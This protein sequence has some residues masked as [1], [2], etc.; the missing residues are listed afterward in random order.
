MIDDYLYRV[1]IILHHIII[2]KTTTEVKLKILDNNTLF[3]PG[4]TLEAVY[5]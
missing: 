2:I 3:F 5:S 1:F 4:K